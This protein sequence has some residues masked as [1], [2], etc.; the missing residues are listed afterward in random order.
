MPLTSREVLAQAAAMF[1]PVPS[2]AQ[3]YVCDECLGPVTRYPRCFSCNALFNE[4]DADWRLRNM[5]VP[6]TS[7]LSPSPWYTWLKTY[8]LFNRERSREIAC[9]AHHFLETHGRNIARHLGGVPSII[10]IVPSKQPGIGFDAQPLRRTLASS[11]AINAKLRETLRFVSGSTISRREYNPSAFTPV[12]G[13]LEGKRVVLIEDT[14]VTGA[15][16]LS[17]AGSILAAGAERVILM[18]IAR[19]VEKSRWPDDHPYRVEMSR[20]FDPFDA[21]QWPRI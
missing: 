5:V 1:C 9:P 6:M 21:A 12:G 11:S 10:T 20:P 18:P 14:W 2:A 8:K 15:T 17:A 3:A 7:A 13:Q 19:M 4:Q 16:S